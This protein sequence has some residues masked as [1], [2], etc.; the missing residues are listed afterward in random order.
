[1]IVPTVVIVVVNAF[2]IEIIIEFLERGK[3]PSVISF[4]D[5]PP[6]SLI[7]L[8]VFVS[9]SIIAA[10]D[11]LVE[12]GSCLN[13]TFKTTIAAVPVIAIGGDLKNNK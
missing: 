13:K 9:M 11:A 4:M 8:S 10:L 1:M 12:N 3:T 2:I 7:E 6:K 5:E